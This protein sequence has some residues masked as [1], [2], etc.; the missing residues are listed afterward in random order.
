MRAY[1]EFNDGSINKTQLQTRLQEAVLKGV[2]VGAGT[3]VLYLV[4]ATP[5]GLV[6]AGV[7]ILTYE[8]SSRLLA[9]LQAE[10]DRQFVTLDDLRGRVPD[11]FLDAHQLR[12]VG[13][14]GEVVWRWTL[15]SHWCCS[16]YTRE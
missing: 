12:H 3:H 11:S 1:V 15:I 13:Q 6:V 5:H 7:A 14:R 8:A 9:Y 16:Q 10:H 4:T 2:A